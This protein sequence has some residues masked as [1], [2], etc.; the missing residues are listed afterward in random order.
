[1]FHAMA[2]NEKIK[3]FEA[4]A[5]EK[6]VVKPNRK[7]FVVKPEDVKKIFGLLVEKLSYEGLYMSTLIGTDMK[8]EG[9]IRLDYYV[10]LLPEE[11]T[12][13]I[14][15]FIPRDAPEIDSIID[16]LPGALSGECETHDL[17]GVIFRG[18]PFLKRGFF[19]SKDVVEKGAFPLRKDSE[20]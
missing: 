14:R 8:D 19:V 13:V 6:G 10:V 18:N 20:V 12:V 17:L 11:E 5:L 4:F 15:T 3:L 16:I 9:K 2:A 7:L 1:M